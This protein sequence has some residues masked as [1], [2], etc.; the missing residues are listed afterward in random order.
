MVKFRTETGRLVPFAEAGE[1]VL[2]LKFELF[3]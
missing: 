3:D 2:T 1:V